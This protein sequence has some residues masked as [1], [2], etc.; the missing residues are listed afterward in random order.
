MPTFSAALLA[1]GQSTRMGRDK[2]LLPIPGSG[3]LLWQHQLAVLCELKPETIFWSGHP[4][5]GMPAEVR[6]LPDE[7]E[8]AGPL[9]GI[10]ACLNELESD[11]LVVLAVDL[12]CMD[13]SYLGKL[14]Q[15]CTP[16]RGAVPQKGD[17]FEPLAAVY[18]ALLLTLAD[19]RLQ[20]GRYTM[21]DFVREALRR[22]LV[23][24]VPVGDEDAAKFTN[25]NSPG[26]LES[27][28]AYSK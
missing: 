5:S 12:A 4:R 16:T 26:D 10:S 8:N 24:T 6:V 21:Q 1:G 27:L 13:A 22:E 2:A 18:P 28:D 25:V 11:L 17:D 20:Q 9:G 19:D 3:R 23:E 7:I 14:V 15:H